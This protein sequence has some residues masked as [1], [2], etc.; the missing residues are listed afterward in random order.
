ML[1]WSGTARI[2]T[3]FT[4]QNCNRAAHAQ[5]IV[6]KCTR[7]VCNHCAL[8][9]C[10]S[11]K[12]SSRTIKNMPSRLDLS[13][14][15]TFFELTSSSEIRHPHV[16]GQCTCSSIT[17]TIQWSRRAFTTCVVLLLLLVSG[18]Y[19]NTFV[20]SRSRVLWIMPR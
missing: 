8:C 13:A 7:V 6:A 5:H 2:N 11:Y 19:S 9:T 20:T 14:L 18:L 10:A 15:N 3:L 16:G 12:L 1:A 17:M 4:L